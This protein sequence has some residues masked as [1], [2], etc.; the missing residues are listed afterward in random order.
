MHNQNAQQKNAKA[1]RH[2]S[3]VVAF[4]VIAILIVWRFMVVVDMYK[5]PVASVEDT[6]GSEIATSAEQY[7]LAASDPKRIRIPS[8]NVDAAFEE[9]LG[10]DV[11]Q[12]IEVPDAYETVGW[13]KYGPTPGEM[14]PSVVLGHVDSYQGPAVFYRLGQLKEGDEILIDRTDGTTATFEVERLSRHEQ[15]DFPTREVYGDIDHAGLRLITCTGTYDHGS[16]RYSHNLIVFAR[17][18]E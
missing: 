7:E 6:A 2:N 8:I 1:K 5:E 13:Y 14:G 15:S 17:L 3:T 10:L 16:L 12:A 11:D 9:P 18:K 4:A